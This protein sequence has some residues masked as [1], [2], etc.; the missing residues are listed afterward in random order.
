MFA[1]HYDELLLRLFSW[2]LPLQKGEAD[3]E[4]GLWLR[5]GAPQKDLVFERPS[6]KQG[7]L[8]SL[9]IRERI[10]KDDA[11]NELQL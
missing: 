11:L 8:T 6:G 9:P 1:K 10:A 5:K 4:I 2:K 7:M 3:A